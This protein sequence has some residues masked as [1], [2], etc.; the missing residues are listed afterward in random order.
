MGRR[1][2]HNSDFCHGRR[3]TETRNPAPPSIDAARGWYIV[4]TAPRGEARAR[5]ALME[6]GCSVWLPTLHRETSS[7][8]R[9]TAY[10]APMYP[11][12]LFV[13][14]LPFGRRQVVVKGV[15]VT[16]IREMPGVLGV[17]STARGF[18]QMPRIAF[19]RMVAIQNA[20]EPPKPAFPFAPGDA[21]VVLDGPFASFQATVVEALGRDY[22]KVLVDIFGRPTAVQLEVGQIEAA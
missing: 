8:G 16:D 18:L 20:P 14:D 19:E 7:R 3:F 5:D 13:A 2:P 1:A 4:V 10:D 6:A 15:P 12:Y 21:V 9:V 11:G 17:I 22:A